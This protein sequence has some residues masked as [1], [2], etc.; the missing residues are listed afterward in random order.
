M[1]GLCT[2]TWE[3]VGVVTVSHYRIGTGGGIVLLQGN[4]NSC[5]VLRYC[6]HACTCVCVCVC[7]CQ[8]SNESIVVIMHATCKDH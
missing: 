3:G 2:C 8:W 7:V 6:V 1:H 4:Y 5:Q